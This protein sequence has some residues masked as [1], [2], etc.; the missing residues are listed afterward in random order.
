MTG[1]D[2]GLFREG[3]LKDLAESTKVLKVIH[4]ATADSSACAKVG[5]NLWNVYDTAIAHK[6]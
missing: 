3:R 2:T 5:V 6:V 4:A 1:T